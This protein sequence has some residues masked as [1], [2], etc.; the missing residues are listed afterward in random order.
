MVPYILQT[1]GK[2]RFQRFHGGEVGTPRLIK[3]LSLQET[4]LALRML[5][6]IL[7]YEGVSKRFESSS[8][9]PHPMTV[10]E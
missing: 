8:I 9:D 2:G 5:I 10:H 4:S 6:L 3:K 1:C 7:I